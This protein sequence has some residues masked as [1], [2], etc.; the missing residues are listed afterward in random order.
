MSRNLKVITDWFKN[1]SA[2]LI[3]I[4]PDLFKSSCIN[5]AISNFAFWRR[6]KY[7]YLFQVI[8]NQ[9]V[10]YQVSLQVEEYT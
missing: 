2:F 9:I 4:K 3:P 7:S 10:I 8:A 6:G 5:N 1:P